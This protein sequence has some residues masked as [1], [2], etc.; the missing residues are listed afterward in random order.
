VTE[1]IDNRVFE[2]EVD[3]DD[4]VVSDQIGDTGVQSQGELAQNMLTLPYYDSDGSCTFFDSGGPVAPEDPENVLTASEFWSNTQDEDDPKFPVGEAA[5]DGQRYYLAPR[6]VNDVSKNL[7][8][9]DTARWTQRGQSLE[10]IEAPNGTEV[11]TGCVMLEGDSADGNDTSNNTQGVSP[12]QPDA[13][14]NFGY[15]FHLP[16]EL[17]GNAVQGD[18]MTLSFGFKFLQVR[19]TEAPNFG[20]YS[21][22]SNTPNNTDTQS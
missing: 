6:T 18:R 21:P 5:N 22:G 7:Q 3:A 8:S 20:S 12:L 4:D 14:L 10:F 15:D 16:F 19:H 11:G 13:T 2:P 1:N 17:T 9:I